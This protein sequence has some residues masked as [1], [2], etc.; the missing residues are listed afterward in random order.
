MAKINRIKL[1]DVI[2]RF[3]KGDNITDKELEALIVHYH[4]VIAALQADGDLYKLVRVHAINELE[5]AEKMYQY[6]TGIHFENRTLSTLAIK[7]LENY[8]SIVFSPPEVPTAEQAELLK[9]KK[10]KAN[11]RFHYPLFNP[12]N[13]VQVLGEIKGKENYLDVRVEFPVF[14]DDSSTSDFE[15]HQSEY[16]LGVKLRTLIMS[17]QSREAILNDIEQYVNHKLNTAE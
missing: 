8:L 17:Q 7:E 10:A 12:K 11:E 1:S 13:F 2:T 6:R 3:K 14:G 16:D 9:A 5:R 15:V 4:M